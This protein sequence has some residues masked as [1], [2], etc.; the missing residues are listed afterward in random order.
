MNFVERKIQTH[1]STHQGWTFL[2]P[3]HPRC[4]G[5]R[6]IQGMQWR[7]ENR[8]RLQGRTCRKRLVEETCIPSLNLET[9]GF[10][11]YNALRQMISNRSLLPLQ[12]SQRQHRSSLSCHPMPCLL[13]LVQNLAGLI[14]GFFWK[15]FISMWSLTFERCRGLWRTRTKK[16]KFTK[17]NKQTFHITQSDFNFFN[18]LSFHAVTTSHVNGNHV[19]SALLQFLID[20]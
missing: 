4:T 2:K 19:T 12:F 11:K 1:L 18:L 16:L 10:P 7:K 14:K 3:S 5:Q 6:H 13:D 15:K 20:L 9:L 8:R 17:V